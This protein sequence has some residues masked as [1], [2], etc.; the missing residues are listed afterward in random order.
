MENQT[1]IPAHRNLSALQL[2]GIILVANTAVRALANQPAAPQIV[3]NVVE[4]VCNTQ[5]STD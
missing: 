4:S 3:R 5:T 1:I 2:F